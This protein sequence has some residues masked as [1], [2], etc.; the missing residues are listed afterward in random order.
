MNLPNDFLSELL[1]LVLTNYNFKFDEKFYLQ[2][3]GT[4]SS[5][6]K[7]RKPC[8]WR[9]GDMFKIYVQNKDNNPFL[10]YIKFW[11][12]FLMFCALGVR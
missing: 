6:L 11:K 5:R 2:T 9:L 1:N 3:K 7:L 10:P 4:A 8:R 12:V